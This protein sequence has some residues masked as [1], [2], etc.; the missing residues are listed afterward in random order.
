MAQ[1]GALDVN[2]VKKDF[3]ILERVI[4]GKRLVYLD[5]GASSQRPSSV[6]D[7]MSEYYERSH[8]N[9]H[10]SVYVL[11]EEAT[12]AYEGAR[13]KV[14]RFINASTEKEI[15]FGK[16]VTE[17]INLVARTWGATNLKA[18]DAILLTEMEHHANLVP[19]LMLAEA[20]KLE[21][22]YLEVTDNGE[23]DLSDIDQKLNGVKLFA[24]TGVSNVLGTINP[25]VDLVAKARAAGAVTVVDFAQWTPHM[26][27]DVQAIGADFIGFTA[28][29][30]LGPT[31]I[32][33]LWGKQELLEAMPPFLGG[34]DMILDVR[35]DGFTPNELP[36][37][38]EAGTPPIAEAVGLGAAVDYLQNV[39]LSAIRDH[40][41]QITEYALKALSE[42]FGDELKIFG[43]LDASKRAGVIS[44]DL[45]GVHPHDVGQVLSEEGVCIRASHHCAKPLH[46]KL[47]VAATARA[48]FYIYNDESDVDALVAALVKAK[49]FFG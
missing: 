12:N 46:R 8:A 23:L 41:Q 28:H 20:N 15:L 49:E 1:L 19:W 29:K 48:S 32:G 7:A 39:G 11:A 16:N 6:I 47:G 27:T 13:K 18:G 25:V 36:W 35:L 45:T 21:L 43:P 24:F 5:S 37:K 3:P 40:E 9:V 42:R 44:F 31:G 22:R 26:P 10:R 33:V 17:Q 38:F 2:S 14:A 30:M 34:G 4:N